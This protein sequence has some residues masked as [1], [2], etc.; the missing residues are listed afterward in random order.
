MKDPR[1]PTNRNG[2]RVRVGLNVKRLRRHN[3]ISQERLGLRAGLHRTE[4]GM[5]EHGG[6]TMQIDTAMKIAAALYVT[7]DALLE[8]VTW[9]GPHKIGDT[10]RFETDGRELGQGGMER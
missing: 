6:R 1:E 4:V 3:Q 8:G 7:V 2:L 5:I 9:K 10:G